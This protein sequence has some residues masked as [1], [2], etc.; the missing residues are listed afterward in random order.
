MAV[1]QRPQEHTV[2]DGEHRGVRPDADCQREDRDDSEAWI[3]AQ[4]AEGVA[5]VAAQ[6]IQV[7]ARRR[8]QHTADRVRPQTKRRHGAS[9][10]EHVA[11][12]VAERGRHVVAEITAKLGGALV[13][14][15]AQVQQTLDEPVERSRA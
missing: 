13:A 3:A 6:E 7:L 1:G 14:D 8:R 10:R 9:P 12:L 2:H 15:K 5:N 4:I 11:P